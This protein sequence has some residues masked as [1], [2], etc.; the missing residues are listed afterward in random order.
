MATH[1]FVYP[2]PGSDSCFEGEFHV[3]LLMKCSR[4]N[5]GKHTH[6]MAGLL[7]AWKSSLAK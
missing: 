3:S 7:A 4:Q 1:M 2:L 5:K 6:L